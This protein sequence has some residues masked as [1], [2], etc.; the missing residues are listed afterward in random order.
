M[1][2]KGHLTLPAVQEMATAMTRAYSFT[3]QMLR[4][5][6]GDQSSSCRWNEELNKYQ[7]CLKE[8][9]TQGSF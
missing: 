5:H 4:Q 2:A 8:N 3:T 9:K 6:G 1:F 7:F